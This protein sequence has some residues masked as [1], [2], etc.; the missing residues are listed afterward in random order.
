MEPHLV[1]PWHHDKREERLNT[2]ALLLG[3]LAYL[4]LGMSFLVATGCT[5][6]NFI[7]ELD[8]D[9]DLDLNRQGLVFLAILW[10]ALLLLWPLV[11]VYGVAPHVHC[12]GHRLTYHPSRD[13]T[14]E[15]GWYGSDI[16]GRRPLA[17]VIRR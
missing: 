14:D 17:W 2:P 15:D 5:L 6:G 1:P 3:T 9:D 4:A 11:A 7:R 16:C 12:F 8:A 13:C 10:V